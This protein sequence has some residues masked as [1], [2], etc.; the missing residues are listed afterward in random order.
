MTTESVTLVRAEQLLPAAAQTSGMQRLE[1]VAWSGVWSGIARTAPG[2]RS[3][4]H[5]HGGWDTIAYVL[6]GAVRL[7][8]GAR[9]HD[10][11]VAGPGD[12]L[13][14]P[15]GAVHRESN[16]TDVEQALVIVRTG[17][18]PIVVA[19]DEPTAT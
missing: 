17:E 14:I 13:K 2:S 11:V 8:F 16:P 19:A 1:A 4:W 3:G 18:G 9:G 6:S 12:F 7:E 5:H 10:A 15:A